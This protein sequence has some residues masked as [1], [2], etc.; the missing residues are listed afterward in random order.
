MFIFSQFAGGFRPLGPGRVL[1]RSPK[2]AVT[3]DRF[4]GFDGSGRIAD[5]RGR[6]GPELVRSA[7]TIRS[8][9]FRFVFEF[10]GIVAIQ[11]AEPL[12]HPER[13]LA[14]ASNRQRINMSLR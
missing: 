1:R 2:F 4:C 14:A 9:L 3:Q 6:C 12:G 13:L 5:F 11:L 10:L 7:S 8:P